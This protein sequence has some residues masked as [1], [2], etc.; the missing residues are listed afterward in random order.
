MGIGIETRKETSRT[1]EDIRT[2]LHENGY[3]NIAFNLG[4][5]AVEEL[6][7][8]FKTFAKL[9]D[10]RNGEK[11]VEALNFE[12]GNKGNG[13]FYMTRR[14]PG[15]SNGYEK[16]GDV[17]KDDKLVLHFG[18]QTPARALDALGELPRDMATFLDN[19]SQFY[20]EGRRAAQIG[21][22]ALGIDRHLFPQDQR[23]DLHLL[24][25]ID[26][27]ATESEHLGEAHF[28]RAVVTL[29]IS[30]SAPGLRGL[31]SDNG[32]LVPLDEATKQ[33]LT[34]GL[35]P[36]NHR[37]GQAK[38]FASAGLRRLPEAIRQKQGLD[39]V[40]LLAH[41]I[42]NEQPGEDR[43]AVVMFF[44]PYLGFEPYTVPSKEETS[45]QF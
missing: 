28:D 19:C 5:P 43:Q 34:T 25:L 36:I 27:T 40:P 1:N 23:K 31:P 4:K 21:A 7:S 16:R 39:E 24:R 3:A 35:Q 12:V 10:E 33:R 30:E 17:G 32:Y 20:M 26:Y 44:N 37:E 45:I 8:N 2:A 18:S 13:V 41:D 14:K 15:D 29:A 11:L 38:F 42:V 22:R 9:C 6:F